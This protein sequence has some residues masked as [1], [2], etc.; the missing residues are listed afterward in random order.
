MQLVGRQREAAEF[1]DPVERLELLEGHHEGRAPGVVID[2][3]CS[4]NRSESHRFQ[5]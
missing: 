4:P 2:R 1:A 3:F 5:K